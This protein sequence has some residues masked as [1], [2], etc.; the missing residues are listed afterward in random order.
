MRRML[1][2]ALM[3]TCS[4]L[5]VRAQDRAPFPPGAGGPTPVQ[6]EKAQNLN[7]APNDIPTHLVKVLRTSNKAQ[8]NRY[9]PKVYDMKN[10]NPADV[11]R[12]FRRPIEVE[13]S[14]WFT[15]VGP[16]G[17]SGKVM[18]VVPE[19]QIPYLDDVMA[20]IDRA[21]L[22]TSSGTKAAYYRLRHRSS[23]DAT[24]RATL[25]GYLSPDA[26]LLN[27]PETNALFI[28]DTP[29]ATDDGLM[30]LQTLDLPT[31]QIRLD[32]TLYEVDLMNDGA[33]GL[34]FHAWKNGPGRSLFA[35]G[36]FGER[37]QIRGLGDAEPLFNSGAN[38]NDLP[39]H[40][41]HSYGANA[42]VL[43]D[44]PS[45]YFD[46]LAAKG[47]A[48]VKARSNVT[49]L[50]GST[51]TLQTG[52]IILY[53]SVEDALGND[54]SVN[55]NAIASAPKGGYRSEDNFLDPGVKNSTKVPENRTVVARTQPRSLTAGETGIFMQVVPTIGKDLIDIKISTS[56]INHVGYADNGR[57]VLVKR[58][59]DTNVKAVDGREIV[60]G[61]MVHE[62][63]M[64]TTRKVPILGSLPVVGYL[65]GGELKQTNRKLVVQVV[66]ATVVRDGYR[67]ETP[68][69]ASGRNKAE[70]KEPIRLPE[71]DYKLSGDP[72]I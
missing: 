40:T 31:A 68:E 21:Q 70:G 19:Y 11:V 37:E 64:N 43:L 52:D 66:R 24:F 34:D 30:A 22:T 1:C 25:A 38:T 60:M 3:L 10:V 56:V 50:H 15:Y 51:A 49:V 61:G 17:K 20:K 8:T 54:L 36:A 18:V 57:P 16:D 35:V 33:L 7:A 14:A 72:N 32:M 44:M 63:A 65:S 59:E 69:D 9:V 53:Y 4:M 6:A 67:A 62:T 39:N 47:K 5:S 12:F 13:E 23:E 26:S 27:D 71:V 41:F 45:A 28:Y 2:V 42:A 55:A 46:F 29:S 58:T 48:K